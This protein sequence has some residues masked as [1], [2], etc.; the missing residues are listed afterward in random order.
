MIEKDMN[1]N[2]IK[3]YYRTNMGSHWLEKEVE[4]TPQNYQGVIFYYVEEN[5]PAVERL[6]RMRRMT[7]ED[8]IDMYLE[9]DNINCDTLLYREIVNLIEEQY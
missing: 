1:A 9:V 5:R 4:V 7:G 8:V 3:L 2:K 6:V